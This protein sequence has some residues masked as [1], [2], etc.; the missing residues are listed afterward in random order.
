MGERDAALDGVYDSIK[1]L[2][3]AKIDGLLAVRFEE[4]GLELTDMRFF[5]ARDGSH[6]FHVKSGIEAGLLDSIFLGPTFWQG[7]RR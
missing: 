5:L 7:Y 1:P 4:Q 2:A 6:W 3:G